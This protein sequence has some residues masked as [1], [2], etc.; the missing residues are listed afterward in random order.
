VLHTG[1]RN[2]PSSDTQHQVLNKQQH[3]VLLLLLLVVLRQ[4][5]KDSLCLQGTS[6]TP[7]PIMLSYLLLHVNPMCLCP[8]ALSFF[9]HTTP[10][11]PHVVA[12]TTGSSNQQP[13]ADN[14]QAGGCC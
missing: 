6:Y 2:H 5:R 8:P 7:Y 14:Q 12:G 9:Y 13:F 4:V 1:E 10:Y 3:P 11:I